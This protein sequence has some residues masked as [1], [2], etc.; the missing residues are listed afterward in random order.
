MYDGLRKGCSKKDRHPNI[1]DPWE[2][3]LCYQCTYPCRDLVTDGILKMNRL[4][5]QL[6]IV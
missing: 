2:W 4:D 5:R 6:Y 1:D 3:E